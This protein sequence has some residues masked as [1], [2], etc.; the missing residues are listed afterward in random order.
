MT[1]G[2]KSHAQL[3]VEERTGRPLGEL[4]AD[5]YVEQRRSQQEIADALTANGARVS[6][7]LVSQWLRE[8]GISRDTRPPLEIV[9]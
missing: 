2:R 4:L 9:A 1:D 8:Q 7:A 6:R 5:L 3:L